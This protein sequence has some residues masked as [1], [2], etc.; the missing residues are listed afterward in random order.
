MGYSVVGEDRIIAS[1]K[2]L[3]FLFYSAAPLAFERLLVGANDEIIDIKIFNEGNSLAVASNNNQVRIFDVPS[4]ACRVLGGHKDIV[5]SVD[6]SSDGTIIASASKD[7]SLRLWD[8][9]TGKCV[10]TCVG[11]TECV[12]S[13]ALSRRS[14]EFLVSGSQDKTLKMWNLAEAL[15]SSTS[16]LGSR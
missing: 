1:N 3:D 15:S 2:G 5:L 4:M 6:V 11:H 7:N 10:A 9:A 16:C 14:N 8:S 12:G 13:V